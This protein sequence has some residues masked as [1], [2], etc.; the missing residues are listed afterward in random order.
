MRWFPVK[1][2]TIQHNRANH[3]R[4]HRTAQNCITHNPAHRVWL[5]AIPLGCA[6]FGCV[7][8]CLV[9]LCRK[10]G[11]IGARLSV[12][13]AMLVCRIYTTKKPLYHYIFCC[14][15]LA[16]LC[17]IRLW[18]V[19]DLARFRQKRTLASFGKTLPLHNASYC[20][21]ADFAWYYVKQNGMV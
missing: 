1:H 18:A 16:E 8:L 9:L 12:L 4:A 3:A 20:A 13:C 7:V 2:N 5:C 10:S 14:R 19:S 17:I 6:L 11:I 21:L 15:A